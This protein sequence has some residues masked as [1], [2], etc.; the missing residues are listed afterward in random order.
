MIN[1]N[2]ENIKW[3]SEKLNCN[4][5]SFSDYIN[6]LSIEDRGPRNISI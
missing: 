1:C 2:S 5:D 4:S 3:Y 6:Y